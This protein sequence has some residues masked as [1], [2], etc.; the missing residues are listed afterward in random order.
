MYLLSFVTHHF[1]TP[2]TVVK[3]Y[4]L[5]A[6]VE[7]SYQSKEV[8]TVRPC[9]GCNT[10]AGSRGPVAALIGFFMRILLRNSSGLISVEKE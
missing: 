9:F 3:L 6:L 4:Y 5:Y 2:L 8:G 7:D 10:C 1:Y